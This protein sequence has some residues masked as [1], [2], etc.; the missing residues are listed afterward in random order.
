MSLLE[1]AAQTLCLELVVTLK[2][3]LAYTHALATVYAEGY[4]YGILH[5]CVIHNLSSNRCVAETLLNEIL[6]DKALVTVDNVVRK[7]GTATQL[8]SL[9]Q[10][11]L[12]TTTYT[13]ACNLPVVDTGTLLDEEL[14]IN[15]VALD[16]S[17]NLDVREVAT[18][19]QTCD[20]VRDI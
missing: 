12:L 10:V 11:L 3:N 4:V 7:L 14:D 2:C 6:C 8:K 9:D 20:R 13:F 5:M 15:A 19:P 1:G 17:T 16:G 18:S